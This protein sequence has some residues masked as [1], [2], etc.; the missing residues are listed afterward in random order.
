[1]IKRKE[2]F[3]G[4]SLVANKTEQMFNTPFKPS[5]T[6]LLLDLK[7]RKETPSE[8]YSTLNQK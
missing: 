3:S 1:M 4:P 6:V 8:Y 5:E 2:N 7:T